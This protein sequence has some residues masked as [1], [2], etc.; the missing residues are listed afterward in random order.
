MEIHHNKVYKIPLAGK[1]EYNQFLLAESGW[2]SEWSEQT[3]KYQI[4]SS[5]FWDFCRG[6]NQERQQFLCVIIPVT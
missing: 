2:I 6:V 4:S 1:S 3:T 5:V